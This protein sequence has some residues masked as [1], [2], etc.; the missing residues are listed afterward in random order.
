MTNTIITGGRV[1]TLDPENP[2]AEA[3]V[4]S[5]GRILAVGD[6]D[7]ML[8]AAGPHARHV[9]AEGGVVMPGLID[10][11]PHVLH[12]GMLAGGLV[13]LTDAVDHADIV[14]RI[15]AKAANTPAGEWIMCT[16]VGEPHYFIRRSERDLRERRL[17]DRW[18]L[19]SA[20]DAHPVLIQ[21]WAP[22]MPNVVAFNT[23]GLK[24]VGL[25]AFVPDRVCDVEIDK[26]E[27]GELTGI[28]RGPV[29]NY[30]TYDPFWGQILTKLP[31]PSLE[32]ATAG[33]LAEMRRYS[34][35]GVTTVYEGHAMEPEHLALYRKL[36]ADGALSLRV[37]ATLDAE[38][39]I[40]YPFD[41]L[42]HDEFAE[43]LLRLAGQ[44][45]DLDDELL[46]VDGLTLSPGG[47]CF[48]GYFATYEPYLGPFGRS[49]RGVRFLSLEKEETFVRFCAANG[50]RANLCLGAFREHDEFLDIA[51]RIVRE[52]D[53]RDQ[54]WILQHAMTITPAQARRYADLGFQVTTSVGFAW[55]KGAMYGERMGEHVWRD[56]EPLQRL[57]AAGLDLAGGSD[58]GPKNPWEQIELAQTH[59]FAG[60]DHRNDGP[61]QKLSR[62]DAL[63]MW[64]TGAAT[65]LGRPEI[66]SLAP[67][68][69][70]DVLIVDR[71]PLTCPVEDL[72]D[73]RV[74]R[75]YLGGRTVYDSSE[76]AAPA[77]QTEQVRS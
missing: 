1:R 54:R 24:A 30:Y 76:L 5:G 6:R 72:R 74:L 20:T 33:V 73:T 11:H 45:T 17:P 49:T 4:L 77:E 48:S 66:G 19:D 56:L 75:T 41:P 42:A 63:R 12:F 36:R 35:Q 8:D 21:A 39:V 65:V 14:A 70:A 23:A 51:E 32:N 2:G 7:A 69:H 60:S 31:R 52:H 27:S 59:R 28:L 25:T 46:R 57:S 58:W 55:G 68:N 13:D 3:L 22:R 47:P 53:F 34:A 61:D 10:T 64:T 16:P 38:S 44:A 15:R 40:F 18:T 26:N 37:M 71:D 43:R 29:T 62:P 50:I 67:G 9:D